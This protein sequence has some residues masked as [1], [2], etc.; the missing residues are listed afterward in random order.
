M[1]TKC[2]YRSKAGRCYVRGKYCSFLPNHTI[3]ACPLAEVKKSEK[4]KE[5]GK[6]SK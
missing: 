5:E 3:E 1:I 6:K 4:P 2:K